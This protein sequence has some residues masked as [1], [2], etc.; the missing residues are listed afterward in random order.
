[1]LLIINESDLEQLTAELFLGPPHWPCIMRA[2]KKRSG[3]ERLRQQLC[4]SKR[5]PSFIVFMTHERGTDVMRSDTSAATSCFA[6][7]V[8]IYIFISLRK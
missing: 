7:I 4:D 3:I 8:Y 6:Y 5:T 1:M 2:D